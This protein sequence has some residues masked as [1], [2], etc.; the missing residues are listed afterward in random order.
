M[1]GTV[2][3]TDAHWNKSVAAI[4]SL[5]LAGIE[6]AISETSRLAAGMLSRYPKD[7]FLTPSPISQPKDFLKDVLF[8]IKEQKPDVLL[9]MELTT[10]LLLS[11]HRQD[12][13]PA[14][15]F[16]F[17][18]HDILLKAASKI[19]ATK[20]AQK[21]GVPVPDSLAVTATTGADTI[22]QQ[23][24]TSLVLKPDFGEGGR[25]LRYCQS[26]EE[27]SQTLR[28]IPV[29]TTFLAQRRIP[30]GG[31]GLGVSI[32]MDENQHVLAQFS[33]KRIREYPI[34]G[35][36]SCCRQAIQH[37][38]AEQYAITILKSL[39]FQGIAM[40]EFK[41]DPG[42]RTPIFLEI[43]PRF[44][45]SL[46][47]AIKAGVDFPTLLWKWARGFSFDPPK[48][49]IGTLVRNLL[50]GDLL[51]FIAQKGRVTKDFWWHSGQSDDLL[52]LHDPFPALGRIISPIVALYDPQLKSVFKK[53]Q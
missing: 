20:A 49:E 52:S 34:S 47:L 46:P 41:E 17:A 31:A 40:V 5:S 2:L 7:R 32:L 27:L 15:A 22:T 10:L 19:A 23:L 16:P 12:I 35:G 45:G 33:H 39:K 6:V 38:E 11:E 42:T 28:H 21:A 53:R 51:H 29:N 1:N 50:P 18:T 8:I 25:G 43:N 37:P 26:K 14:T 24:G 3:V 30:A 48:A 4:R 9:P 36:P 44:W 13:N